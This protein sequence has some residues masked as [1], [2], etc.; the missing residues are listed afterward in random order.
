M[1]QEQVEIVKRELGQSLERTTETQNP[2]NKLVRGLEHVLELSQNF[3][4]G[5]NVNC[6]QQQQHFNPKKEL[7]RCSRR[8]KRYSPTKV[9]LRNFLTNI[10]YNCLRHI[11]FDNSSLIIDCF[12]YII[13][14]LNLFFLEQKFDNKSDRECVRMLWRYLVPNEFYIFIC[15]ND[16]F[17][18]LSKLLLKYQN[19]SQIVNDFIVGNNEHL[20]NLKE[21]FKRN[22]LIYQYIYAFLFPKC[23]CRVNDYFVKSKLAF[24][25]A[26]GSYKN[27]QENIHF[28][29]E[30]LI[31]QEVVKT[32]KV[33]ETFPLPAPTPAPTPKAEKR[34]A[35]QKREKLSLSV[36]LLLKLH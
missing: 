11:D 33:V 35:S 10:A 34:K 17:I 16:S 8:K 2:L 15:K 27:Q 29:C 25:I 19:A 4:L 36:I 13:F 14:N 12:K 21:Y 30:M 7:C 32:S 5:D 3:F 28:I 9:K 1:A 22:A 6:G 20:Q 31:K 26:Y 23:F 24:D 18:V